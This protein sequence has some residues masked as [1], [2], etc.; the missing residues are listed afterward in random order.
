MNADGSPSAYLCDIC[1]SLIGLIEDL[2]LEDILEP[3]IEILVGLVCAELPWPVSS[4]C[5]SIID[6]FVADIVQMIIDGITALDICGKLGLCSSGAVAKPAY[7]FRRPVL[8]QSLPKDFAC[9]LCQEMI[10]YIKDVIIGGEIEGDIEELIDQYCDTFPYPASELCRAYMD[11]FLDDILEAIEDEIDPLQICIDIGMCTSGAKARPATRRFRVFL[12]GRKAIPRVTLGHVGQNVI[13]YIDVLRRSDMSVSEIE[14]AVG[15]LCAK[16]PWQSGVPCDHFLRTSIGSIV[17]DLSN[18]IGATTVCRKIGFCGKRA[19]ALKRP[20]A[21]L[22]QLP[23]DVICD[24]CNELVHEI[25]VYVLEDFIEV[26]IEAIVGGM[27]GV[28]PNPVGALCQSFLDA[29]VEEIIAG[30]EAGIDAL[31]I[32]GVIG[33]CPPGKKTTGVAAPKRPAVQLVGVSKSRLMKAVPAGEACDLCQEF[34]HLIEQLVLDDVAEPVIEDVANAFC[35]VLPAPVNELCKSIVDRYIDDIIQWIEDGIDSLQICSWLFV[36]DVRT[37]K[38]RARTPL[39]IS[40][41]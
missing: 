16:M 35:D 21:A 40:K 41:F 4:V 9:D 31:D 12:G 34:I 37:D 18:G 36:C 2:V 5:D 3:D 15:D 38:P 23:N 7:S 19:R 32:C 13:E 33:L 39:K 8:K 1:Q 27:C 26:D 30:L 22:A 10:Q 6:Q 24:L 17:T 20:L 25:E 11:M 14:Q 28:L 29:H